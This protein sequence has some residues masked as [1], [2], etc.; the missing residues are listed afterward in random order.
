MLSF[1]KT[2]KSRRTL[3]FPEVI[4][5]F[6]KH[7]SYNPLSLPKADVL[8]NSASSDLTNPTKCGKDLNK[9][10]GLSFLLACNT[11]RSISKGAVVRTSGGRLACKF[12]LHAVCCSWDNYQGE[13]EKVVILEKSCERPQL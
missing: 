1:F 2:Y 10:G 6:G 3:A 7:L 13:S 8:V 12:V 5:T 9:V 4:K 11:H